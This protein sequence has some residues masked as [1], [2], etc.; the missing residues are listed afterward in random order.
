MTPSQPPVDSL[1]DAEPLE[2]FSFAARALIM[3]GGFSE[4]ANSLPSAAK[5]ARSRTNTMAAP[6]ELDRLEH[7]AT[8]AR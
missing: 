2:R 6:R 3:K 1:N 8:G 5:L 4:P 7:V